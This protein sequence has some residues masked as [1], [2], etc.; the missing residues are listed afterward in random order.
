MAINVN[1]PFGFKPIGMHAAVAPTHGLGVGK[2]VYNATAMYRGDPIVRAAGTSGYLLPWSTN[3]APSLVIGIFW[4]IKHPSVA[5]GRTTQS[6]YWTG[7]DCPST[8]DATCYYIPC[9]GNP[10]PLFLAQSDGSPFVAAD[11]GMNVDPV[12]GSG[13]VKGIWGLSGAM[14]GFSTLNA[15][16]TRAFKVM[17]LW[18]DYA[19]ASTVGTDNTS[20][21]NYVVV[22]ANSFNDTGHA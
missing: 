13:A 7:T 18:S 11:V 6:T 17:A 22:A 21:Y 15:S 14:A 20:S 12:I 3:V 1:A 16:A 9:Q 8:S 2:V 5:L 4:G 10:S 19:P